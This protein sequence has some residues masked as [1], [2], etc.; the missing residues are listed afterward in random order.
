MFNE[1]SEALILIFRQEKDSQLQNPSQ[2]ITKT[3]Q[4]VDFVLTLPLQGASILR[5]VLLF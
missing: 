2:A 1:Q 4:I 5:T 3:E